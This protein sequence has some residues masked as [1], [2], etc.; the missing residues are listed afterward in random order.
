[1]KEA[2]K[3]L[4]LACLYTAQTIPGHFA[5]NAMP[6]IMRSAGFSLEA[7][8]LTGLVSL[9]WA[10]K[11]LWAPLVDRF[12]GKTR[13]YGK[14]IITC[15]VL[16]AL[17]SLAASYFSLGSD[18]QTLLALMTIS[19]ALAATQDVAVDAFAV[20]VLSPHE[21][22]MGNGVQTAGN[23][24]GIVLGSSGA[25]ALYYLTSWQST[26]VVMGIVILLLGLPVIPAAE[27]AKTSPHK[28]GWGDLLSFFKM[29][30][31]VR[32]IPVMLPVFAG[33]FSAMA[34]C[35]PL[36]LDL[37]FQWQTISRLLG[38]MPLLGVP[39][40]VL[41]GICIKRW[42]AAK[43]FMLGALIAVL[44]CLNLAAAS[45]PASS[46]AMV[47]WALAGI[48]ISFAIIST[49]LNTVAMS[50]ARLGREGTDF[51]AFL[52]LAF[53]GGMIAMG[54]SGM[55]A[56]RFGY[57]FLF[58]MCA[59]LCLLPVVVFTCLNRKGRASYHKL[60]PG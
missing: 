7:I 58:A 33:I 20:R 47:V 9:P 53:L 38:L 19:Y 32:W 17:L 52:S 56:Q 29:P 36:L 39:A 3:F 8:G 57:A 35:K 34:M 44:T 42:G 41:S 24:A 11:F 51:T 27:P 15:Q 1:M 28:A 2:N 30:G 48:Y 45:F 49:V 25:L 37:G 22:A 18:L 43:I 13:H 4:V 50:L 54:L 23:L 26:L 31:A 10:L 6:V 46:R 21:R 60:M 59:G 5:T 12:G 55:I 40:A 14:W 16:F